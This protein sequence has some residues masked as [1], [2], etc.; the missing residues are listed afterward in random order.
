MIHD[1]EL[2]YDDAGKAYISQVD[3]DIAE[4][5]DCFEPEMGYDGKTIDQ[6]MDDGEIG[7]SCSD[8]PV[9]G[10]ESWKFRRPLSVDR[11]LIMFGD[12]AINGHLEDQ[13]KADLES[14]FYAG[15]QEEFV[16]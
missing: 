1:I 2:V 4:V 6:L 8:S 11:F 16:F 3:F 5:Q 7:T 9:H 13:I 12:Y 15:T 14:D 10:A